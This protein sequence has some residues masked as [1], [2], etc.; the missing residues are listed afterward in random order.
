[1]EEDDQNSMRKK[2]ANR[3]VDTDMGEDNFNYSKFL[4]QEE[5]FSDRISRKFVK[6]RQ[7]YDKM[8]RIRKQIQNIKKERNSSNQNL[9]M[10]LNKI[11]D[12][13][14]NALRAMAEED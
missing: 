5:E 11:I 3:M 6:V 4:F 1:M 10:I 2:Y 8:D 9:K 13:Q 7:E 14:K 12:Q